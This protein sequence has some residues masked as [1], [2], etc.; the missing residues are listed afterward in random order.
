MCLGVKTD[1]PEEWFEA[2]RLLDEAEEQE[3]R[4]NLLAPKMRPQLAE[5]IFG[6]KEEKD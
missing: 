1:Y 4:L 3:A 5:D 6:A 2:E